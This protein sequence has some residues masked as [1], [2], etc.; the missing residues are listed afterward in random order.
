MQS[1]GSPA[2][3]SSAPARGKRKGLPVW[4]WVA[5]GG[6]AIVLYYFYSKQQAN[7][8]A[9]AA[10][11]Q[12]ASTAGST[13]GTAAGSYGNAGDLASLVPYLQNM[14]GSTS[15]T[16]TSGSGAAYT[17]PTGEPFQGAGFNTVPG[18]EAVSDASGNTY[19]YLPNQQAVQAAQSNGTPIYYQPTPGVFSLI[20]PNF[21][22]WANT[23]IFIKAS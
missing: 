12:Q 19:E 3:S 17:P 18:G 2:S 15:T 23:P 22:Q 14:N 16:P 6:G 4:A 11:A 1:S 10:N 13:A 5:I 7:A 9:Q 20:G 8:A 21:N